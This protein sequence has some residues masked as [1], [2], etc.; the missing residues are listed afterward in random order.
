VKLPADGRDKQ[1]SAG[2]V[3]AVAGF[4]RE[5]ADFIFA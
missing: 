5:S 4:S 3:K 2:K 1:E